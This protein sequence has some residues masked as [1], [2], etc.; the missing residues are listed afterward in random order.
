MLTNKLDSSHN[1]YTECSLHSIGQ[2]SGLEQL[3]AVQF[4]SLSL[5]FTDWT[6]NAHSVFFEQSNRMCI[7]FLSPMHKQIPDSYLKREG[8]NPGNSGLSSQQ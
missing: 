2:G 5:P 6:H 7:G 3:N 8:G 4:A 1:M